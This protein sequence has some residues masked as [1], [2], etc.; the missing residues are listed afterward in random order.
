MK[1]YKKSTPKPEAGWEKKPAV[2]PRYEGKT[3]EDVIRAL[4]RVK[5]VERSGVG[6]SE[7]S[8]SSESSGGSD[9]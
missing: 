5:D 1:A 7:G 6:K 2:N 8:G 3:A 4:F 9:K